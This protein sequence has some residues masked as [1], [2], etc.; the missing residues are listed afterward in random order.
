MPC[1]AP[2]HVA[3]LLAGL[4]AVL[5]NPADVPAAEPG[6]DL[7]PTVGSIERLDPRFNALVP[8]DAVIEVLASGFAW[9]NSTR[10]VR[11]ADWPCA[12][13]IWASAVGCRMPRGMAAS[14]AEAA[15]TWPLS[16][17][18]KMRA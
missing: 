18:R 6:P 5:L 9:R 15:V 10:R 4:A 1:A 13:R 12:I 14:S 17:A 3:T 8:A 11:P 16:I 2:P 7:L